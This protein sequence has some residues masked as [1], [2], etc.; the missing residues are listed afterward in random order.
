MNTAVPH[1]GVHVHGW[2]FYPD[3]LGLESHVAICVP[4]LPLLLF[5]FEGLPTDSDRNL[6]QTQIWSPITSQE[7]NKQN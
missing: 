1:M 3:A 5:I 6:Q 4:P 2:T 7:Y